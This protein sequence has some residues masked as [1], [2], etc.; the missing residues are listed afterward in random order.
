MKILDEKSVRVCKCFEQFWGTKSANAYALEQFAI[1]SP[2]PRC[3]FFTGWV[4]MCLGLVGDGGTGYVT[5]KIVNAFLAGCIPIYWGSRRESLLEK[6]RWNFCGFLSAR[7]VLDIFNPDSFIFANEIQA[8][9]VAD[10]R[11]RSADILMEMGPWE[12]ERI[13]GAL[14]KS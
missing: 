14:E 13:L 12:L 6:K 1:G 8:L 10:G 4:L 7:S 2:C 3:T 5:E 11:G 9:F